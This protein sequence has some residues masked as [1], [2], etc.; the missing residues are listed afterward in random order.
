MTSCGNL[1][2]DRSACLALSAGDS[3]HV[4]FVVVTRK[5]GAFLFLSRTMITLTSSSPSPMVSGLANVLRQQYDHGHRK[6]GALRFTRHGIGQ[7]RHTGCRDLGRDAMAFRSK[8][9]EVI[10]SKGEI[11][12]RRNSW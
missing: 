7:L 9:E 5:S 6:I 12:Q 2:P 11:E 4:F 3:L 8:D 10:G 1:L